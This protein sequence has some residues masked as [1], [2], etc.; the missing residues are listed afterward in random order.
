MR[1][2]PRMIAAAAA[3][4]AAL[5][6]STA[7]A[8]ASTPAATPTTQAKTASADVKCTPDTDVAARFGVSPDRLD[9]AL[10]AVKTSFRNT[11]GEVTQN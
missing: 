8:M 1:N 7:A 10:R 6:G 3:F 4:T 11:S 2:R 9:Q 5:A